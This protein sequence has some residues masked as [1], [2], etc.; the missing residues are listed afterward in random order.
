MN[1]TWNRF[2]ANFWWHLEQNQLLLHDLLMRMINVKMKTELEDIYM[3]IL[4]NIYINNL[5]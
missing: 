4:N 3:F 2:E 5:K 1:N